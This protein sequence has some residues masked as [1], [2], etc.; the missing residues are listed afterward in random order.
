[1]KATRSSHPPRRT[2]VKLCRRIRSD[3]LLVIRPRATG[4]KVSG[5]FPRSALS[6]SA[7]DSRPRDHKSRDLKSR[8]QSLPAMGRSDSLRA[9][10]NQTP[11]VRR[12]TIA[13]SSW[14]RLLR[15][16]SQEQPIPV[17]P[18]VDSHRGR[19]RMCSARP[20]GI[21]QGSPVRRRPSPNQNR[22]N[23]GRPNQDRS[24]QDRPNQD[25]ADQDRHKRD[26]PRRVSSG[27]SLSQGPKPVT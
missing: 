17:T 11:T 16:R 25:R 26:S 10:S 14:P 8:R 6:T 5:Q 24:N 20:A 18:G 1:V 13:E 22:R 2:P 7:P 15:L 12:R 23:P 27:L 19:L 9:K 4:L 3:L 21:Q